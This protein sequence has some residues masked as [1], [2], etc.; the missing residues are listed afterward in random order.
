[1]PFGPCERNGAYS[2]RKAGPLICGGRVNSP[3]LTVP[4]R[5]T[6]TMRIRDV[7]PRSTP[8][9]YTE[10]RP[11]SQWQTA[12]SMQCLWSSVSPLPSNRDSLPLFCKERTQRRPGQNGGKVECVNKSGEGKTPALEKPQ[13]NRGQIAAKSALPRVVDALQ[14]W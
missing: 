14:S 7:C 9:K 6:P 5:S 11:P 1:M 3:T 8:L 12:T 2:P 10:I 13:H 4:Y